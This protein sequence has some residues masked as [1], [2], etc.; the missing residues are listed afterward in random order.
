MGLEE[1]KQEIL[2]KSKKDA[3]KI[4][5]SAEQESK[6]IVS[7]AKAEI[8]SYK[9]TVDTDKC[10]KILAIE[11]IYASSANTSARHTL[12]QKKKE[13][14]ES[15]IKEARSRI[16]NEIKS[17]GYVERLLRKAEKEITIDTVYCDKSL[18]G[19]VKGYNVKD[20]DGVIGILAENK[21]GTVIVDFGIDTILGEIKGKVL[22]DIA[23]IL[24]Q[25]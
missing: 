18:A 14:I 23:G 15:V 21:D 16:V 10:S 22:Q 13:I 3:E 8:E 25:G 4:I 24:F 2:N 17:R 20:R 12:L 19:E 7:S 5:K 9:K 1:V 6:E 11:R